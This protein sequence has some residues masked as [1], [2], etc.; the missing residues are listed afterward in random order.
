[1]ARGSSCAPSGTRIARDVVLVA[2]V[3]RAAAA[4]GA[5]VVSAAGE[6]SAGD[7]PADA[8]M[9]G[10]VDVFAAY[11]RGMIRARTSAAL[12]AKKAKGEC[13][14]QVPYGF[15]REGDRLV[16]VPSEQATIARARALSAEGR[17]LRAVA[18][19]LAAEGHVSR[20]GGAFAAP[21]VARML[22]GTEG[23]TAAA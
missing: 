17:S 1:M 8:M 5:R 2:T 16:A 15:V 9:R 14:G 21:Q 13:V 11:E 7:S 10:I 23:G 4:N 6:G 19:A 3:E 20:T 12:Q 18:A 22:A